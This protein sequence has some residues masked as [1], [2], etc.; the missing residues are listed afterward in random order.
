MGLCKTQRRQARKKDRKTTDIV[1]GLSQRY[2]TPMVNSENCYKFKVTE[3]PG[4]S[5]ATTCR[6]GYN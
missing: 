6:N 5:F 4:G 2:C 3:R 1:I